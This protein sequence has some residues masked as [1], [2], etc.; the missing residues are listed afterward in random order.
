MS[1]GTCF[2][3]TLALS[4]VLV[5]CSIAS[6]G[7]KE[8]NDL[9]KD[10]FALHKN[11]FRPRSI[12]ILSV[13]FPA[14]LAGRSVDERLQQDFY[15]ASRH[16]NCNQVARPIYLASFYGGVGLTIAVALKDVL[17][18]DPYHFETGK[19]LAIG[20]AT[21][22]INK[23]ILK[24]I[25]AYGNLR[26]WHASFSCTNRTYGGLPS[27][28]TSQLA[29]MA[30][31]YGLR[32]G[33][34][35]AIPFSLITGISAIVSISSNEHY[36]SQVIAG[37]TYGL[38]YAFAATTTLKQKSKKNLSLAIQPNGQNGL[39]ASVSYSF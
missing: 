13:A 25:K 19:M 14:Y 22:T 11:I 37:V 24:E 12:E 28:H 36:L 7:T 6:D 1:L 18:K 38:I 9:A 29:Y 31:L 35:C 39:E 32:Y 26:P 27:G 34:R 20:L 21:L 2:F 15:D 5:S 10:M 17:S 33:I 16:V 23:I 8:L 30:G 4:L 3:R